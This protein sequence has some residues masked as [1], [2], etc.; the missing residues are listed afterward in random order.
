MKVSE[1]QRY[2]TTNRIKLRSWKEQ[3]TK[4]NDNMDVSQKHLEKWKKQDSKSTYCVI[5]FIQPSGKGQ[6]C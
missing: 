6:I 3:A 5:P 1:S 2:S 4:T